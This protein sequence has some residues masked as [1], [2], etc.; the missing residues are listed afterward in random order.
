MQRKP[1]EKIGVMIEEI[2]RILQNGL[3]GLEHL[4]ESIKTWKTDETDPRKEWSLAARLFDMEKIA[5]SMGTK[6]RNAIRENH[7]PEYILGKEEYDRLMA[8]KRKPRV[9][10]NETF[11]LPYQSCARHAEESEYGSA[12]SQRGWQKRLGK[13]GSHQPCPCCNLRDAE[14]DSREC[15]GCHCIASYLRDG[16]EERDLVLCIIP[17]CQICNTTLKGGENIP[18]RVDEVSVWI[19]SKDV[20]DEKN[21]TAGDKRPDGGS[22]LIGEDA[23]VPPTGKSKP[24]R[25]KSK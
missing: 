4:Y 17:C 25:K 23:S 2:D 19:I 8:K 22:D 14:R 24:R 10:H 6:V 3:P 21:P 1:R 5:A 11:E 18:F 13:I 12:Y 15:V 9:K 7:R 16:A 20:E